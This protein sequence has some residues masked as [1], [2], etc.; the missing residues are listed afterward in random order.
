M[1]FHFCNKNLRFVTIRHNYVARQRLSK[2]H[3]TISMHIVS[4]VMVMLDIL[5]FFTLKTLPRASK[6]TK[7]FQRKIGTISFCFFQNDSSN[8]NN[9]PSPILTKNNNR[10]KSTSLGNI[11]SHV[12]VYYVD[13]N[14]YPIKLDVLIKENKYFCQTN[15]QKM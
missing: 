2:R 4:V 3:Y 7:S 6:Q 15:C 1:K 11:L 12:L 13:V 14:F 9:K 8:Y 10:T 5:N